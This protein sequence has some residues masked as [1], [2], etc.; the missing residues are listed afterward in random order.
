[1]RVTNL[2]CNLVFTIS[3]LLCDMD[4]SSSRFQIPKTFD[5]EKECFIN[6][7]PKSTVL[8]QEQM[9]FID[10]SRIP[11]PK[12]KLLAIQFVQ[13]VANKSGG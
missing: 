5:N 1:M 7:L 11:R 3:S 10:F 8:I 2:H 4:E 12:F 6:A 9:G 13:E